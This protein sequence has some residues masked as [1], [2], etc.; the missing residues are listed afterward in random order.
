MRTFF[1]SILRI[2]NSTLNLT[3]NRAIR[4]GFIFTLFISIAPVVLSAQ[5]TAEDP[6]LLNLE[7]IYSDREFTTE[8]IRSLKWLEG[9]AGYMMIEPSANGPGE[10]I[11][12]YTLPGGER[13]VVVSARQLTP[14]NSGT[15][16]KVS[17]YEWSADKSK[18]LIFTNTERVWRYDTR[19]DYWV[20][21]TDTGA[22]T[23]L[24]GSQAKPSTLM[25]TK[26]SPQGD[27]VAYVREHNLYVEHLDTRKIVPLT[28]DG[29]EDIINGTFD[30]VYE[31]E[32]GARDGFRWSPD[33]TSIAYWRL[34]AGGIS[35][36]LMINNTDSI[37]SYTIPV[38][39]P[40]VGTTP[41]ECKVG[42]IPA[43]GGETIWMKVPG[44]LHNNY[45]PRMEWAASSD[46]LILQ[47]LN[48]KQNINRVMLG[49]IETGQV[50]TIFTDR[51]SA[52]VVV[53]DDWKWYNNGR[54]FT[55][56]SEQDGWK[57]I[58][59]ISRDGNKVQKL[60]PWPFDVIDILN[61]DTRGG[62]LY[63]IASPDDPTRRY[64]YRSRLDASGKPQRLTP[65]N[66][67]GTHSY[68]ISPGAGWAIHRYSSAGT[69]PIVSLVQLPG[70]K[71]QRVLADNNE[72]KEKLAKLKQKPVEFFRVDTGNGVLLDGY[73]MK[74]YNFDPSK[75]YP[76]LFHVYGEPAGQTVL[77]R[78]GG[79]TYLWHLMFTQQG[80]IIMS[81]DNRGTPA[82]RGR[83]WRKS[84]YGQIGIISSKDQAAA[85]RQIIENYSFVD[86]SRIGIWG[87]SG[88]GS[89]TLNMMFRYPGIYKTGMSV[90]PVADQHLYDNIYQERYMGLPWENEKGY[91]EGSPVTHAR[92]LEGNLLIVHGTGDDNVHYQNTEI[93]VNE[94]IRHNKIFSMMS[95][96]N[97]SHGIYEGENTS[98]HV[99][100]ILTWYLKNNLPAGGR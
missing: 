48:R 94:L 59:S 54:Q 97:R 24:G 53:V 21:N 71:T 22:L 87:W 41:S 19:G 40:K 84:I 62:W 9:G 5:N 30:W 55:W 70:H 88:G 16:L 57:H 15:P 46:E 79:S 65:G 60:T 74:P 35:D 4:I 89:M 7:R 23:K 33:G 31:E 98:R 58:Y 44:D 66:Q 69:P 92:N 36:F 56:V 18:L 20:L 67:P 72:L 2:G 100:E 93:L 10:D 14:Q 37:Y 27:R 49:D 90:A 80:Y 77:D 61:I 95:Y 13:E 12:Q 29:S 63:Y 43:G 8:G 83:R 32:F 1:K 34:D 82:P 38:E 26:F 85:A 96:P 17:D 50:Q 68:N 81:V 11:V 51:D 52:W 25:F 42:V 47:R 86:S 45:I 91:K 3:A 73:M 6:S 28:Q 76:V 78:W 64:L 39:Y 75:K 99:R